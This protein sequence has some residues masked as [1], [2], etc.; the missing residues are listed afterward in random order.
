[1]HIRAEYSVGS[2]LRFLSN[3]DMHRMMERSFRRANIPYA[4]S[5]G[6]NPHIKFSLGTV[7]P[8]GVWGEREYLDLE[9]RKHLVAQEFI[10][11]MNL[12]L[13]AGIAISEC[14]VLEAKPL[15]LMRVINAASYAFVF[16]KGVDLQGVRTKILGSSN[17]IMKSKGKNK[18]LDKDLRQGIFKIDVQ[19][20]DKSDIMK[21]WAAVGQPLNI[22]YDELM[23]LLKGFVIDYKIID[24]YRKGNY[25]WINDSFYTPLEK[26]S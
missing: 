4:L 1:M 7:L 8:V 10:Q 23:E 19:L 14:K 5:Q 13:P 20:G 25:I 16:E 9:L 11:Q 3:L 24:I 18:D 2:N 15:A 6:Y 17:L 12:V 26:V 22:R 21:I